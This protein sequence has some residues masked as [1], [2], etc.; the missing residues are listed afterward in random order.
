MKRTYKP[1]PLWDLVGQS[2]DLDPQ[3][4]LVSNLVTKVHKAYRSVSGEDS[5]KA[6]I[7]VTLIKNLVEVKFMQQISYPLQMMESG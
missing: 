3:A 2:K 1:P 7:S 6:H 5:E 4:V